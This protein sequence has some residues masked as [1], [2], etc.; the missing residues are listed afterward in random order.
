M[1]PVEIPKGLHPVYT[2]DHQRGL[3][4]CSLVNRD[5]KV[6]SSGIARYNPKDATDP[7][8]PFDAEF[9]CRIALGRAVKEYNKS[10]KAVDDGYDYLSEVTQKKLESYKKHPFEQ[11]TAS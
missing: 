10:H 11:L 4:C 7:L 3:T 5:F 1:K 8:H 2:Y 9:G 6:V